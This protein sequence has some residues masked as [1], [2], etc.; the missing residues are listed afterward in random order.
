MNRLFSLNPLYPVWNIFIQF[1]L[2]FLEYE[3]ELSSMY[4]FYPVSTGF[5]QF[6]PVLYKSN[7]FYP[8]QTGF[9]QF[10]PE[11]IQ[12]ESVLTGFILFKPVWFSVNR[13][14]SSTI[15][16]IQ[17]YQCEQ[18][19]SRLNW[20]Y[21]VWFMQ[22]NQVLS[23]S[24]RV[25]LVS[26]VA[27]CFTNFK[28]VLFSLDCRYPLWTGFIHFVQEL[29]IMNRLYSVSTCFISSDRFLSSCNGVKFESV[30]YVLRR[31]LSCFNRLHPVFSSFN[32]FY[33]VW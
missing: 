19:V 23:C 15:G 10:Q 11:L 29:S 31:F 26:R 7:R 22:F 33:P 3:P 28:P 13:F 18:V 27:M 25:E 2:V 6:K 32:R 14:L 1:E 30:Y 16:I 20:F 5:I 9:S 24:N 12:Y 8:V 17:F 21:T 4:R